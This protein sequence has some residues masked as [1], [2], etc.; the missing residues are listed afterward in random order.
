M[1]ATTDAE[2]FNFEGN[3]EQSFYD[4]LLANGIELATANDPQRLGDDFVGVQF[5]MG[6]IAEDEHMSEKPDG[7]LEYD[8]YNYTVS[9][10]VH[11]DRNE[12][13]LPGAAF[14]R[15]HREIVAKIRNL[16]SISR[17]AQVASLNDQITLYWI[18]RLTSSGTDYTAYDSS[19]DETALEFEGDFSILTTAWPA[20]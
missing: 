1:A 4:F 15:Y 9:I 11:T 8:H 5:S 16:L 6:G 2:V 14:S 3:M 18:N 13:S 19:Y 17:A 10:T 7:S 12:N 20:A